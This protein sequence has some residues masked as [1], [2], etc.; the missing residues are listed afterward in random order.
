MSATFP[1]RLHV[2]LASE[3]PVGVVLRRGPANAVCSILWD[4]KKDTFETGQWLRARI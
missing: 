2:L 4:R 3:V 1:A